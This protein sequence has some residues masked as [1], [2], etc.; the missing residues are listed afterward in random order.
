MDQRVWVSRYKQHLCTWQQNLSI[1]QSISIGCHRLTLIHFYFLFATAICSSCGCTLIPLGSFRL[2][3]F[4]EL[5]N[6]LFSL[7][8]FS[9]F[10]LFNTC[11]NNSFEKNG[12]ESIALYQLWFFFK[13][14]SIPTRWSIYCIHNSEMNPQ[15]AQGPTMM[16]FR[17]ERK[18]MRKIYANI[19]ERAANWKCF[20]VLL[21]QRFLYAN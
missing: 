8:F 5:D 21:V 17:I 10:S 6:S 19:F 14:S 1:S 3:S 7:S 16:G 11:N 4:I 12:I 2:C 20:Y 9:L 13:M 15:N 18:K